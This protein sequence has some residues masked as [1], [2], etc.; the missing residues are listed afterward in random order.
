LCQINENFWNN[1]KTLQL[2]VRD[3]II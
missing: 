1:K 3:L 2:V